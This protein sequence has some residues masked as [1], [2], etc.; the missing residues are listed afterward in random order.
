MMV[1]YVICECVDG[2]VASGP[3][4]WAVLARR[5]GKESGKY[6]RIQP[7]PVCTG[8]LRPQDE[9]PKATRCGWVGLK[10]NKIE[11]AG[12]EKE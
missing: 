4:H 5:G 11:D 9:I 12:S 2:R 8:R 10:K 3:I 1:L 7:T 6:R